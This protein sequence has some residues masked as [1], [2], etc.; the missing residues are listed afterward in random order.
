LNGW[1]KIRHVRIK[2]ELGKRGLIFKMTDIAKEINEL[3]EKITY[4]NHRYYVLDDPEISDAEYDRLFQRLLDLEK[5]HPDLLTPDSPSQRVGDRPKEAFSE[6]NHRLPMLSLENAFDEKGIRDFEAKIKRLLKNESPID[7]TVEPKMDGLAVE[8]VYEGGRLSVA[9]TRGDGYVG[10]DVTDNIKTIL[11]VPLTLSQPEGAPLIPDIVEVRG[12]VYMER[13][14]FESLN[15]AQEKRGLPLFANPRNAAAGSLRQLNSRIT[16]RR[17]LNMFCYGAGYL[18]SP[19]F[20]TQVELMTTIQQWGLRVNRPQLRLFKTLDEVITYCHELESR[21]HEFPF[22][23]DGAV[24]K[25]NRLDLQAELGQ[26]TRSPRWALAFKFKPTQETTR[27]LKIEVQVGRTGAL[28]PVAR[29]EP[30]EIGGV[31]V[32]RAT[33]HN[34]DEIKR[35]DI[36]EGDTVVLERA[37][38]VIPAVVKVVKANR[39]GLEHPFHMPETCPVCGTAVIKRGREKIWECPNDLC[40]G[41]VKESLKHF[42]SKGAMNIE[43][44][45]DKIM[46]QLIERGMVSRPSDLYGLTREKLMQLDKIE[47]KSADNLIT[48]IE[49]S[50][51]TTLAKFLYALG[52]RHVGEHVAVLLANHFKNLDNIQSLAESELDNIKGIGPEIA[53]SVEAFFGNEANR[54]LIKDLI[55]AGVVMEDLSAPQESLFSRKTFVITGTLADMNRS[56]A[57]ELIMAKGGKV[58]SSVSKQTDYL[59]AG[60]S[61]G[62]K[63]QRAMDLG[64]TVINEEAFRGM[65]N[66]EYKG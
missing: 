61:P 30:V 24:I 9:S 34:P 1:V 19:I 46:G 31:V 4:H 16:A 60:E 25:V 48:S 64:I 62:S 11:T 6:I 58:S 51:Q 37:G 41:R 3:R 18:S 42:I 7:Y 23:I 13:E 50:K 22:E 36:R 53:A 8:L 55:E 27:I 39:A 26:T 12:E 63:L 20:S 57:K 28:T 47:K 43:G 17:P 44:L 49:K 32:K 65:L 5:A 66:G 33:L 56:A 52:I 45:G 38:D 54:Q 21:R 15:R 40:P 35:K 29:L 2:R 59:L 14:A 10:E